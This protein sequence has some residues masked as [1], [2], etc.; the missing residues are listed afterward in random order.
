M[1][2]IA[3]RLD[4][5]D[6]FRGMINILRFNR[7]FYAVAFI[8]SLVTLAAATLLPAPA[9]LR[10]I[11]MIAATLTLYWTVA[12]LLASHWVYDR[13]G[14]YDWTWLLRRLPTLPRHWV[15]IHAGLDESSPTLRRLIPD[16]RGEVLDIYDPIAMTEP[17]I[18]RARLL[19]PFTIPA[20]PAKI[21]G[22][23]MLASACD[24][25]FLLFAAHE[26]RDRPGRERFFGELR[27]ILTPGGRVVI[28]EHARDLANAIAF[29]PGCLHFY[30][31]GEWRR[32]T[33]HA[34]L[35]VEAEESF[36]PLVRSFMLRKPR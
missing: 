27:R 32:L 10:T 9:W 1:S 18:A 5:T 24:T 35:I 12:S 6:R 20:A 14:I 17:A 15:L 28:V 26:I 21:D 2:S 4:R 16:A 19:S 23:P 22:L 29:G 3:P 30:P 7:T 36:T 8:G 34:G 31:R 25:V 13:S 11:G 33:R